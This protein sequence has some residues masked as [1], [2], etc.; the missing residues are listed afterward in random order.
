MSK[1]EIKFEKITNVRL[2]Y[3]R[4]HTEANK[5]Y[6]IHGLDIWFILKGPK[7]AV[8]YGVTFPQYLPNVDAEYAVR[9]PDWKDGKK[10]SGFDVGYH[11]PVP[12]FEGQSPMGECHIL[13]GQCYYDGSSLAADSFTEEVFST[14]GKPPEE[15]LWAK[16][17]E[18]YRERF[19]SE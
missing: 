6:G 1:E 3:D 8:Q 17:E 13:G 12:M 2:P 18:E 4:R 15:V 14:V 7:G 16:L 11:S 9:F 10:I 19:G 5:N